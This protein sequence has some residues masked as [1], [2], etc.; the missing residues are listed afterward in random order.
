MYYEV[1]L[2][3]A[4][5]YYTLSCYWQLRNQRVATCYLRARYSILDVTAT[6]ILRE[7]NEDAKIRSEVPYT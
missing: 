3:L 7:N 6:T 1:L 2:M 4:N 5:N